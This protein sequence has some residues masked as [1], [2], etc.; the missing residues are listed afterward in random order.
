MSFNETKLGRY[1]VDSKNELKK[2][3]WPTKHET[4][5]H[6][7]LV[8]GISLFVALF[9]GVLDMIFSKALSSIL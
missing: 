7:L 1:L 4:Y 2:V 8:I 6:S 3:A 5:K 9:L